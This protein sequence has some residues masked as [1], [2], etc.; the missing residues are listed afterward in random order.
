MADE[1]LEGFGWLIKFGGPRCRWPM[2]FRM[3]PAQMADKVAELSGALRRA[4]V[5][6]PS[7]I[8]QAVG[9]NT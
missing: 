4:P 5:Q 2:K 1:M 7:Q 9:D 3:V 6:K 8:F